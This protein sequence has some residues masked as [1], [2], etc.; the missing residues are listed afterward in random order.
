MSG[1]RCFRSPIQEI[2]DCAKYLDAAVSAH[3]SGHTDIADRLFR[4]ANDPIVRSWTES[5]WG[6]NSQYVNITKKQ[7]P[8]T[9][10]KEKDRM[11]SAD[12]KKVLHGRDGYHCRFCGLP[13]VHPDIRKTLHKKY[14]EAIP[15]G[16][17]NI[18]Q[19]AGFQCLWL[20][21]DHVFPHSAGGGNT[22]SNLVIT[23]SAC[24]YGK[25]DYTLNELGLLDPR[26]F[27][28]ITSQWDG[29]ERIRFHSKDS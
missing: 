6:S 20:Q 24:N 25:K 9:K 10:S 18:Q 16:R 2:Y 14:P 23:C 12:M 21:Y 3:I 1:K 5:I 26:E 19:H 22:L 8:Q 13:V 11:P 4:L 28:V 27:P 7:P 29:L 15:W 17:T